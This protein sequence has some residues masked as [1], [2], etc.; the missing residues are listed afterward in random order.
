MWQ[1]I[2]LQMLVRLAAKMGLMCKRV[3][4]N[5]RLHQ[6]RQVPTFSFFYVGSPEKSGSF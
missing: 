2:L 6:I 5:E 1:Y 3:V 4:Q